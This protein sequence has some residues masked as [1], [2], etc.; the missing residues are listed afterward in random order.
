MKEL[1]KIAATGLPLYLDLSVGN[2]CEFYKFL[3][4]AILGI[5]CGRLFQ[6]F[7]EQTEN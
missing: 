5:T 1:S 3:R 6:S 7:L 2:F 4:T